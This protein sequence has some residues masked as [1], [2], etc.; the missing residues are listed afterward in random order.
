MPLCKGDLSK[1][2]GGELCRYLVRILQLTFKNTGVILCIF[3]N[4]RYY[5]T[6]GSEVG[7]IH[8]CRT[9]D[10]E[11]PWIWRAECKFSSVQ[12]LSCVWLF[13]IPWTTAC[14]ASLSISNSR[15][16]LKLM[17][18]E[19]VMPS[20]HLI[21]VVPFSSCLQSFPASG[22]HTDFPPWRVGTLTPALFKGQLYRQRGS[23]C[24]GP[25]KRGDLG[26]NE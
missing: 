10:T 18:I 6:I 15:T 13:A 9:A 11:E 25:E 8:G 12:S 23:K 22:L 2:W 24:Q 3:F 5:S 17:S 26:S 14:Q 16:L 21:S 19:L 7:W 20:N 1:D 4:H